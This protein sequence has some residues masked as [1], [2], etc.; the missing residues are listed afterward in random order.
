MN[1]TKGFLLAAGMVFAMA[2]TFSCSSDGRGNN[3]GDFE[4]V[5]IGTQ[6]WM[7]KNLN[8]AV[9]GSKCG[10]EDNQLADNN[11]A[12][13]DEYGRLYD[14]PTAMTVCPSGWHLPSD[15]EWDELANSTDAHGFL[16][17]LGGYGSDGLFFNDGGSG[18]WWS[19]AESDSNY[20]HGRHIVYNDS[21]LY[22]GSRSK[23]GLFSVRCVG[24]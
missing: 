22:R 8:Y 11:T 16:A 24:D 3:I 10:D 15:E 1:K 12:Y 2:F 14:W 18:T 20:A 6:T 5:V 17:T 9:E 19:A 23:S 4:T 21:N 13:C 7:A